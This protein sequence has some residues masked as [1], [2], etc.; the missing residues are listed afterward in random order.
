MRVQ[1]CLSPVWDTALSLVALL[2]LASPRDDRA[3]PERRAVALERGGPRAR[4]LEVRVPGV[5]PQRLVVRV[6]ERHSIPTSTTRPW[7]CSG[8]TRRARSTSRRRERAL[9]WVLAMQSENGGWAA[10]DK[11]NTSRLPALIPFADFGEMIDPPSADV[12]GHVIEMLGALGLKPSHPAIAKALDYLYAQQEPEG[13][14]FGRWGVNHIYGA[15]AVLPALA[16]VGEPMDSLAVTARGA[17]AGRASEPRRR[18]RRELRVL[19]RR[20]AARPRR[21]HRLADRLGR[22]WPRRR[23]AA[24]TRPRR[25]NAPAYL[26]DTQRNDGSWNE[27]TFTGCGFPGYGV[28]EERGARIRQG[29]ELRPGFM[30][31]YHLYRN[32]FPLLALGRYRAALGRNRRCRMRP[33]TSISERLDAVSRSFALCIPQLEPPFRERVALAYL[34]MRVLD[35]VE[36]APFTDR[37]SSSVSSSAC[38]A[39]CAAADRRRG[40]GLHRG[41]PRGDQRRRARLLGDCVALFEDAHELPRRRARRI[42]RADRSHGDRDGRVCAAAAPLRLLDLEDVTRYC[43]FVAGL[44]GEMLTELWGVGRAEVPPAMR[45]PI[46]SAVPAEG[47]H[48][49]GSGRGRGRRAASSCRIA[50]SCSRACAA[51]RE[52]ALAYL[53]ALPPTRPRLP[54]RSAP[55][56]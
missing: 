48:P 9:R 24:P 17:L 44:V 52:G 40:R 54:H 34:L 13:S 11:D 30:L 27:N 36:D 51:T 2:D 46:S 15:G 35:T 49:Q 3:R 8:S 25:S 55:G 7:C 45:S 18:L 41:V 21:E 29:T 6:R 22:C 53:Q 56:R 28:G 5:E 16:A 20:G 1:A 26:I 14:W 31:R 19:C 38:A 43:C 37:D 32:C 33:W 12:T 39:F 42:F 23:A 10:F 47:E 4:R 50:T